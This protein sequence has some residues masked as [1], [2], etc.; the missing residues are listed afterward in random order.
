MINTLKYDELY[1]N[2]HLWSFIAVIL[3]SLD[4]EI[5]IFT[6]KIKMLLNLHSIIVNLK[7]F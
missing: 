4:L 7:F 6:N 2:N 1:F 3:L 5:D